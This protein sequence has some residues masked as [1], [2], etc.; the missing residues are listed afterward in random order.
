MTRLKVNDCGR[1]YFECCIFLTVLSTH[2]LQ[3][4]VIIIHNT[5]VWIMGG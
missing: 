3:S 1:R 4:S 2:W 5:L